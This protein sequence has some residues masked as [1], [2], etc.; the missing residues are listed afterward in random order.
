MGEGVFL[1]SNHV[2]SSQIGRLS[3]ALTNGGSGSR[4]R[5]RTMAEHGGSPEFGFSR[6]MVVSFDEVCSY[7]IT[8][9]R[10]T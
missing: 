1:G 9:T 2:R 4:S 3:V 5:R 10:G 6:A 8:A 7:G